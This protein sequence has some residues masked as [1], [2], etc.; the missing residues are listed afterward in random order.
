MYGRRLLV[1]VILVGVLMGLMQTLS[2]KIIYQWKIET[3]QRNAEDRFLGYIKSVRRTLQRFDYLPFLVTKDDTSVKYLK[4]QEERYQELQA[5][6]ITLD[7]AA[8]TRGWYLLNTKGQIKLSSVD[9]QRLGSHITKQITEKVLLNSG[10]V[11]HVVGSSDYLVAA[12]LYDGSEI[13]GV[14]VVQADLNMLIEQWFSKGEA[15]LAHQASSSLFLSSDTLFSSSWFEGYFTHGSFSEYQ[16][17]YD[18]TRIEMWQ[19][20]AE[21]YL[22][23]SVLL[24][25]LDWRLVYLTPL[26]SL[27][28]TVLWT[29]WSSVF[30]GLMI[31]LLVVVSRQRKQKIA[32]Y[33]K[34]QEWIKASEH[35][36]SQMINKTHVG[37]ILAD[38]QGQIKVMNPMAK[39]YFSLSE[40]MIR[41]IRVWQLF[42]N[43][44]S[45]TTI[46][47]LLKNLNTLSYLIDLNQV[48][49][50]GQ[51]SDG[52]LFPVILSVNALSWSDERLYLCT[53]IDISKRKRAE[54]ALKQT[55]QLLQY[56]VEERTLELE[57]AHQE[58]VESSK[59]AALG[60][61][62]S[63]IVHELNQPLTGMKTLFSTNKL[64]LEKGAI[65]QVKDNTVLAVTLIER[66][67]SMTRQLKSF[68]FQRLE[69]PSSVNFRDA[70]HEVLTIFQL[71]LEHVEF[72]I[73]IEAG[74]NS[75]LGEEARLRQV[76]GNLLSNAIDAVADVKSPS[77]SIQVIDRIDQVEFKISDN[78]V[79]VDDDKLE[80][81]FEP[82]YT[83][84]KI[85][86]GLGLGL[87]I[88]AN[89]TRDMQGKLTASHNYPS[90]MVFIL[91]MSKSDK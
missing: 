10:A 13:I 88:S 91:T 14:I 64:L 36:L 23:Q 18:G 20:K 24:D 72:N 61:M 40:S 41:N 85:G 69:A 30:I 15:I 63:A 35:R 44:S 67:I 89:N 51:R 3:T 83:T 80:S 43:G 45:D 54:L 37:L 4:G 19:I 82:F 38:S 59:M 6:L 8:N 71:K 68:A 60:R 21:R 65:D 31:F 7:K 22:V 49:T 52:S 27:N 73:D 62:S 81:I 84:K 42:E 90:G 17:L 39:R 26:A 5:Q 32:A 57:S 46:L 11:S 2:Q 87:A 48:E 1:A 66:M 86:E 9:N 76:L 16:T 12:P 75:V 28:Q 50:L 74:V 70:L 34:M 33:Q 29:S 55:N 58:L 47:S 78:G 53:I 25:D 56:K 77:I 79:G